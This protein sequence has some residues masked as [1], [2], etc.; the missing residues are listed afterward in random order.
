MKNTRNF[1]G[2]SFFESSHALPLKDTQESY[3]VD[4]YAGLVFWDLDLHR[5]Q[6]SERISHFSSELIVPPEP[7]LQD[8]QKVIFLFNGL[9]TSLKNKTEK[10]I[11]Q[12]VLTWKKGSWTVSSWY[13]NG[14]R[15]KPKEVKVICNTKPISVASGDKLVGVMT[16]EIDTYGFYYSCEFEGLPG[17]GLELVS[18]FDLTLS[19]LALEAYGVT[20]CESIPP[21]NLRFSNVQLT[22]TSSLKPSW[23]EKKFE[24]GCRISTHI[25]DSPSNTEII[26]SNK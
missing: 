22:T 18:P 23:E 9:Q 21:K 4:G 5:S 15:D 10:A 19:L 26:F 11:L 20:S 7:I 16:S 25:S 17:S 6:A 3:K 1:P 2:K 24:S 12:P 13:V 14:V 8:P